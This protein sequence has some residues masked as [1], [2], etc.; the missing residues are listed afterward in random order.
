MRIE[1]KNR[2]ERAAKGERERERE[3]EAQTNM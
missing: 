3:R 2:E 1:Q